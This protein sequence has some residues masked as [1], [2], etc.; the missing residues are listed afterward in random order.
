MGTSFQFQDFKMAAVQWSAVNALQ[1]CTT[2]RSAANNLMHEVHASLSE[3]RAANGS[4][5]EYQSSSGG[6]IARILHQPKCT[7]GSRTP[8]FAF[9]LD[10]TYGCCEEGGITNTSPNKEIFYPNTAGGIRSDIDTLEVPHA[11]YSLPGCTAAV[12][13]PISLWNSQENFRQ[14]LVSDLMPLSVDGCWRWPAAVA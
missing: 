8:L 4:S 7:Y 11:I 13:W 2:S 10:S 14:N 9:G 6:G 5:C 1:R 12:V 3:R